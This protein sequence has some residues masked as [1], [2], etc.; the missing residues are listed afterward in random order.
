[1]KYLKAVEIVDSSNIENGCGK[2]KAMMEKLGKFGKAFD[3]WWAQPDAKKKSQR[4]IKDNQKA[5]EMAV[6]GL[7]DN[8]SMGRYEQAGVNYGQFWGIM[9]GEKM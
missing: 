2:D 7:Q 8:W 9:M 4:N 6:I 5:F 1:L 3:D